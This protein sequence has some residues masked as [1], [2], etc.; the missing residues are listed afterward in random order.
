M[1]NN[2]TRKGGVEPTEEEKK[3]MIKKIKKIKKIKEEYPDENKEYKTK[4][5]IYKNKNLDSSY[6]S[7]KKG[8]NTIVTSHKQI[9]GKTSNKKTSN[10]KKSKRSHKKTKRSHNKTKI[11]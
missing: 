11:K 4:Y 6:P 5:A 3:E 2:K 1:V 7:I 10:K 8:D 9:A